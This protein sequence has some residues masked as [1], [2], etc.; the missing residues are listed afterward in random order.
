[1]QKTQKSFIDNYF[2]FYSID[3][4]KTTI[5]PSARC[6]FYSILWRKHTNEFFSQFDLSVYFIL[7]KLDTIEI[8]R[9]IICYFYLISRKKHT[10]D[11]FPIWPSMYSIYSNLWCNWNCKVH[12]RVFLFDFT[13]KNTLT[14][15]SQFDPVCI[16]FIQTYDTIEIARSIRAGKGYFLDMCNKASYH[17]LKIIV[18]TPQIKCK[19]LLIQ[20]RTRNN[21]LSP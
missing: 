21:P 7:H 10:N 15:F 6:I 16:P 1:M 5:W 2:F 8:A 13:K 20:N 11:F 19:K 3:Y 12:Y 4:T 18:A 14:I 17:S 9:F